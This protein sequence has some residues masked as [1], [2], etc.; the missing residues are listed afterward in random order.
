MFFRPPSLPPLLVFEQLAVV[1]VVL[2]KT[3][4]VSGKL[5]TYPSPKP[6]FYPK[7]EIS[8]NVSLGEGRRK[9]AV[10]QKCVLVIRTVL[11]RISKASE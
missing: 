5:P 8:V 3:V 1:V 9:W 6:T 4:Y 7:C 11:R 2:Y 10:S